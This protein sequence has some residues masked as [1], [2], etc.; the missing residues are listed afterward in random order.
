M[1][2]TTRAVTKV[3]IRLLRPIFWPAIVTMWLL[4]CVA[5]GR[6]W[7]WTHTPPVIECYNGMTL[8]PGQTCTMTMQLPVEA[9][10]EERKQRQGDD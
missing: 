5:A 4:A 8:L 2:R 3:L 1:S 10:S 6:G 7:V 9:L